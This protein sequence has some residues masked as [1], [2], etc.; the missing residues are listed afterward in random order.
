MRNECP[1]CGLKKLRS[2]TLCEDCLL[3]SLAGFRGT[4]AGHDGYAL[5]QNCTHSKRPIR[6]KKMDR[7]STVYEVDRLMLDELRELDIFYEGRKYGV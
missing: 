6:T 4:T 3:A 5:W 7:D 1:S 2:E